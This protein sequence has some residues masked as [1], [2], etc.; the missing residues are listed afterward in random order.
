MD[1]VSSHRADPP[2]SAISAPTEIHLHS[3]STGMRLDPVSTHLIDDD[4]EKD[5][6]CWLFSLALALK[7]CGIDQ[8]VFSGTCFSVSY[9]GVVFNMHDSWA[10][11]RQ[12]WS[13]AAA[14]GS[15]HNFALSSIK[16]ARSSWHIAVDDFG[17]SNTGILFWTNV[18]LYGQ[19]RRSRQ[20]TRQQDRGDTVGQCQWVGIGLSTGLS[21]GRSMACPPASIQ[22]GVEHGHQWP[23]PRHF[24]L[25]GGWL[26]SGPPARPREAVVGPEH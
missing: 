13:T 9:W 18:G 20:N 24:L 10:N 2:L 12:I 15:C 16:P 26:V 23:I 17:L 22:V 1:E 6:L 8:V 3:S 14:N 11:G 7:T 4:S 19:E 21:S 5:I 25:A